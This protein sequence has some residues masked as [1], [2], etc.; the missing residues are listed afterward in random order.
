MRDLGQN[1]RDHKAIRANR[2]AAKAVESLLKIKQAA[3]EQTNLMPPVI[4]A[5]ENHCTLGEIAD[6]LRKVFGEYA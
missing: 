4:E 6:E 2:D 1:T 5:V 3:T